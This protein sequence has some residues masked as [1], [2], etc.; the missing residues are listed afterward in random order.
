MNRSAESLFPELIRTKL[1]P[2][3]ITANVVTRQ[4]LLDQLRDSLEC[5]LTLICS[6]A[7]FGK[8][9]L[10]ST[11]MEQLQNEHTPSFS[12]AWYSLDETDND[13]Q[14]FL[15]YLVTAIRQTNPEA[16]T[17][18]AQLL[19]APA[20]PKPRLLYTTFLNDLDG[21]TRPLVLVIEDYHLIHADSVHELLRQICGYW[22]A[23]LHLILTSRSSPP[24]PLARM[25]AQAI[26]H[27]LRT[28]ELRFT[29]DETRFYLAA[30]LDTP[31]SDLALMQLYTR[32][33]G[34]IAGLHLA[35][36]SLAAT[37]DPEA[38]VAQ[39]AGTDAYIAEYLMN[40]VLAQQP[41]EIRTLLLTTSLFERFSAGL[42]QAVLTADYPEM[43]VRRTID[44]IERAGLFVIPLDQAHSWFR[45][46]ALFEQLLKYHLE[47]EY[48]ADAITAIHRRAANWLSSHGHT[49]EALRHALAANEIELATAI[50]EA[51]LCDVLNHEDRA[52]LERWL[53][54]F[55][56]DV[57]AQS[58]R[59][60]M[61]RAWALQFTWQISLQ[62]A[63]VHQIEALI[64]KNPA[65]Q[66]TLR[67]QLSVLLGQA[68]FFDQQFDKAVTCS[69][70]SLH[71]LSPE[72]RYVRGGA[73]IYL[74]LAMQASG[75]SAE[76]MQMLTEEYGTARDKSDGYA[77]RILIAIC[78]VHYMNG[79]MELLQR[80]AQVLVNTAVDRPPGIPQCWGHY[81]LGVVYYQWNQLDAAATHF[82]VAIE[83][84]F[85]VQA[86]IGRASY[87]GLT[88]THLAGREADEASA[89]LS[90]LSEY[91]LTLLSAE[92]GMTHSLRAALYLAT[93]RTADAAHWAKTQRVSTLSQ[94][95]IW[96]DEPALTWAR[97]LI[98][99]HRPGDAEAALARLNELQDQAERAH[100]QLFQVQLL[101][102]RAWAL[103]LVTPPRAIEAMADLER[104]VA[105]AA[106]SN[107]VQP[108]LAIG[109]PVAD[110]LQQL[111]DS[112][113]S[114][115]REFIAH[116]LEQFSKP[117]TGA[118]N[119]P[120]RSGVRHVEP[121]TMR[122]QDVLV[123]M[124]QR[125]TDKEIAQRLN[126]SV[127]T[128]K[129]HASNIYVK[130]GVS[131]RWDAVSLAEEYGLFPPG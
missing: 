91:D 1:H 58:P 111:A 32:T 66:T 48:P 9:T 109:Q 55:P 92:S 37:D 11:W 71:S 43:D 84:R 27:E 40:E 21:L 31:L 104:A 123:L 60:L 126:I 15:R 44:Q 52:T 127:Q 59:L 77:L 110:L 24:F 63:V 102:L 25:R 19:L 39:L 106:P 50:I 108:F 83:H 74:G 2:P 87:I 100:N 12:F 30:N 61:V 4:R 49:D 8:T 16:C 3:P 118:T 125:L 36:L 105:L 107:R 103:S 75:R 35:A 56:E 90:N 51:N 5:P 129:R 86:L 26:V 42:A 72:W 82:G 47:A 88:L 17:A 116:L 96:L 80:T 62:G 67:G 93:G 81:F 64:A 23:M 10:L 76:V 131:R 70:E 41:G 117:E 78:F 98:A 122:E 101:A 95:L 112:H 34:W 18:T 33:E 119:A 85:S 7:G 38:A 6:P 120:A 115:E 65:G 28:R 69:L 94:P 89:V 68:A 46:H 54:L 45:Y 13:L 73:Q 14:V 53:S 128:A 29:A 124:R 113:G 121:L 57:V 99:R 114:G 130:L 97:I 20:E 22:P 79:D